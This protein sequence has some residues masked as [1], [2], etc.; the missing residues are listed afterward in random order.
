MATTT[1]AEK[2]TH[3]PPMTFSHDTSLSQFNIPFKTWIQTNNKPWDG[4]ATGALVFDTSNRVLLVQRT[5]HDSMPNLWEVP[6]GAVDPEDPSILY[7]CARELWEEAGLVA[8]RMESLV[9]EGAGREAFQEFRNS[10]GQKLIGK[11]QFV[12]EIGEGQVV[13]LDPNEHQ[14]FVWATEEEVM[15]ERV[16]D[17]QTPFTKKRHRDVILEAFSLRRGE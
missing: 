15:L 1:S 7:G 4:I 8:R 9:T 13:R 12:V 6:G 2:G 10:T 17:K 5:S 3:L 11:F 14:D 16:G